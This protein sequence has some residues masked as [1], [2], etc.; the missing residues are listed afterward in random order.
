MSEIL[1]KWTENRRLLGHFVSLSLLLPISFILLHQRTK[2]FL[3][4]KIWIC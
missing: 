1:K 2:K 3:C 4:G